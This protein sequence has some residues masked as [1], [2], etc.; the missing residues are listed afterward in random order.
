MLECLGYKMFEGTMLVKDINSI[1][2]T[3]SARIIKGTWLYLP[4]TKMWVHKESN[5][6][7]DEKRCEVAE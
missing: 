7:Y 3:F 5:V 4:K 6:W 1:G 2:V